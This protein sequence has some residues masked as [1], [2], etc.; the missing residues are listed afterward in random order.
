MNIDYYKNKVCTV[1]IPETLQKFK[2]EVIYEYFTG[3]VVDVSENGVFL[4]RLNNDC[5]TF[6]NL[7]NI[8]GIAEEEV[9]KQ[10]EVEE[11]IEQNSKNEN[12]EEIKKESSSKL[13][14]EELSKI[15]ESYKNLD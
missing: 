2:K 11:N 4:K 3:I 9:I 7:K 6:F 13:N 1:F 10:K 14:I 12:K 8:I 15:S 5:I